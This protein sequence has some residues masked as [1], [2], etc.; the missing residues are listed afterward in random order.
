ME[1]T[2]C[3]RGKTAEEVRERLWTKGPEAVGQKIMDIP[4]TSDERGYTGFVLPLA[5]LCL[6]GEADLSTDFRPLLTSLF[7]IYKKKHY[8]Q[9]VPQPSQAD[10][11]KPAAAGLEKQ[12]GRLS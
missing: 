8:N 4:S 5:G 2:H 12:K 10:I 3:Q 1:V 11:K 9:T 7:S 6:L